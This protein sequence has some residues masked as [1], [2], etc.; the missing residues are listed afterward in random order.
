MPLTTLVLVQEN[1]WNGRLPR[2]MA[3]GIFEAPGQ[4]KPVENTSSVCHVASS[5][6][7]KEGV[8]D[9][10]FILPIRLFVHLDI[11]HGGR[12]RSEQYHSGLS[13]T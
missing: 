8:L 13:S 5:E 4:F 11:I 2:E 10:G 6:L 12:A 1:D 9:N 7:K 3:G